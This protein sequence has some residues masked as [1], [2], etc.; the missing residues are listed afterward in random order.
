MIYHAYYNVLALTTKLAIVAHP[1]TLPV[2][3]API[4]QYA[5]P[6]Q[7]DFI[8]KANVKAAAPQA[9]FKTPPTIPAALAITNV[10][11]VLALPHTVYLVLHPIFYLNQVVKSIV[12]PTS[13]MLLLSLANLAYLPAINAPALTIVF[14]VL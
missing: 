12:L 13:I 14:H 1:A 6:A 10:L 11:L 8:M 7:W 3:P 2:R 5:P 9:C 4:H